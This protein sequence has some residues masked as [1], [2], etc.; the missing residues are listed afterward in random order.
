MSDR[1]EPDAYLVQR[2]RCEPGRNR[3]PRVQHL[4]DARRRQAI[5][6]TRIGLAGRA[7]NDPGIL[8]C[9]EVVAAERQQHRPGR[10][11]GA[12]QAQVNDLAPLRRDSELHADRLQEL[13]R[14]GSGSD[15]H[16]IGLD[17]LA[18]DTDACR[19]VAAQDKLGGAIHQPRPELGG[20]ASQC[21][22]EPAPID[23]SATRHE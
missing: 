14:P 22:G 13:R 9:Q 5:V 7:D 8:E 11:V 20:G 16:G 2:P 15:H 21:G 3:E 18:I 1:S 17:H 19:P 10:G 6:E 23:A 4:G 12:G